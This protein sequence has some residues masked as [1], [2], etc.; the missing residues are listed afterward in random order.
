MAGSSAQTRG[1]VKIFTKDFMVSA[2]VNLA[3]YVNYYVLMVVMAGYCLTVYG[4]DVATSGFVAS[5]FIVGAL[6][7]RFVGG[8]IIDRFGRGRCLTAGAEAMGICSALYLANFPLPALFALRV[9]H[10][11]F[12]GIAQTSVSALATDAV[13]DA[14]KGEGVGYFMLSATVGSAIGPFL[15]TV[16]AEYLNYT[17]LYLVCLG[18]IAAG[19]FAS[20]FVHDP[21]ARILGASRPKWDAPGKRAGISLSSFIERSVLPVS[22]SV[23][24]SLLAYGAVITYLDTFAQEQNMM[25][26]ASLFFVVYSVVMFVARPFTG[27]WFDKRGDLG[28]MCAGFAAFALGMLAMGLAHS[29][30]VLLVAACL[31]GF[32]VGTIN[33]CGLTLAVQRS[34]KNRVTVANSTYF[35]FNDAAIGLAP[36][37]L[38]WSIPLAGYN[39]LYL[40]LAALVFVALLI[41]LALRRAGML[42]RRSDAA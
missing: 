41:Y 1:D 18:V 29:G 11:F 12:Y 34:P 10:G 22:A 40:A 23:A 42:T 19:A 31:L 6:I 35:C 38:G 9:M 30:A 36:V 24:L 27:K 20:L 26:A 37:L 3:L 15:G 39:G 16:I 17:M 14:R 32:G 13:P 2:F 33:P 5:V 25:Q 4:A 7:A 21:K 8:G 28:V